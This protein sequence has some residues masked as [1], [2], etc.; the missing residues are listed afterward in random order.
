MRTRQGDA[1][2][3]EAFPHKCLNYEVVEVAMLPKNEL[4]TMERRF[5]RDAKHMGA[6]VR[7][8]EVRANIYI[9]I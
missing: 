2:V 5:M 3:N 1:F 8:A 7:H 4:V 6:A 9:Y